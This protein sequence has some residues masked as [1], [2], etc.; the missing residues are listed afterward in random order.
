[1]NEL[2]KTLSEW[3]KAKDAYDPCAEVLVNM[4]SE[5]YEHWI[6]AAD[7]LKIEGC[8]VDGRK[9][10]A[11]SVQKDCVDIVLRITKLLWAQKGKSQDA[12]RLEML[13]IDDGTNDDG[14]LDQVAE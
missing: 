4:C 10:P 2:K 7:Q 11:L 14:L 6:K 13:L 1:M 5:A 3:L 12:D 9:H 8:L